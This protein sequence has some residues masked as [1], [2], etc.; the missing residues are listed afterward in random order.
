MNDVGFVHLH[1]HSSYSLLESANKIAD[2]VKIAA[3]D[4]QPALALT[5]TNNLFG[6]L[7]FSEKASGAGIQPIVGLHLSVMFETAKHL[8]KGVVPASFG[9]VL[10]AQNETG[11]ENL[12][13]LSSQAYFDVPLGDDPRLSIDALTMHSEGL[14]CLTGGYTGPLDVALR[15]NRREIAEARLE[16][17]LAIYGRDNLY[18]EIQRHGLPHAEAVEAA[19]IDMADA[20]AL[21]LVATNEAFFPTTEDYEAHDA[22]LALSAGTVMSDT[23]RRQLSV[24]FSFKTRDEMMKRFA[25]LPDALAA[26]VEI[27]QR[28]S[29][30]VRTRKPIL[31][32][33]GE[34]DEAADLKRQAEEG[35]EYRLAKHGP[36]DGFTAQQYEV[37]RL[38]PHRV[39]LHQVGQGQ[40]HPRRSRPWLG[41]RLGRGVVSAH[42]R[43]GSPALGSPVRAVPEPRARVDAR[44]RRRLLCRWPSAGDRVRPEPL[45]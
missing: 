37:P 18:V 4:G 43:S 20:N 32:S 23:N 14:I 19:L 29:Y 25:D 9:I 40:R 10:L 21:S 11:Y 17:L 42:H 31:P 2:L 33:F 6:A 12:M 22:L 34:G 7:E 27:A 5:D 30:R 36:A 3:K 28:C 8:A 38:L 26:T 24:R 44:L 45:R 13:A 15:N 41:R 16:A 39:G 1:V 35:L